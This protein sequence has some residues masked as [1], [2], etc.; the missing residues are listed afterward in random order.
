MRSRAR[1]RWNSSGNRRSSTPARTV[2]GGQTENSHG[3]S[4]IVSVCWGS[5]SAVARIAGSTSWKK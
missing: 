4:K 3:A 2:V 5:S 1:R